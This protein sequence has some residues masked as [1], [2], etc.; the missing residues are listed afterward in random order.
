MLL[1]KNCMKARQSLITLTIQISVR[2]SVDFIHNYVGHL[3]LYLRFYW[4]HMIKN[5][6]I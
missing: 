3:G 2:D 4:Y 1:Q 6:K 5:N